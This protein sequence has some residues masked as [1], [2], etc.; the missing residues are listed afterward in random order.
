[1]ISLPLSRSGKTVLEVACHAAEEAGELLL[2][3]LSG[4]KHIEYKAGRA[5]IVTDVDL[6][7]EKHIIDILRREYPSFGILSEESEAIIG[8]SPLTWIIDPIDGTNNYAFG[9]PFFCVTLAL[10]DAECVLLGVTY[11]PVR[12]EL[13]HAEQGKGTFR[14]NN[15]V[16]VSQ[17]QTVKASIIG[18]DMGYDPDKGKRVLDAIMSLWPNMHGI[19]LMGSAA[20]GL[21]YVACGRL[22]L[23]LQPCLFPW[24][25]ASGILLVREAGGNVLDWDGTPASPQTQRVIAGNNILHNEFRRL[26]GK[27]GTPLASFL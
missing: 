13:F 23:Y 15:P 5:N 12:K 27:A 14:N 10:A 2:Q 8:D 20:L 25:I 21:A 11:D 17:R 26:I 16:S 1:M 7:A 6:L 19:R 4:E 18:C 3:R 9:I 24:D 22:D